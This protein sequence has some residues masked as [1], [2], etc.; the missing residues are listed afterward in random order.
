MPILLIRHGETAANVA[1]IMQR[2]DVPLSARG[3]RQAALLAERLLALGFAH[4]LCSDL[5]RARMTA[6][7]LVARGHTIE[8]TPL[9]QER[10]F[11]DLRGT[12]YAELTEDPFAP[13]FV[14]PG[15]ESVEVFHARVAQAFALIV[16]RR[17]A[18]AG[19]LVV[20]TH[21]LVCGALVRNHARAAALPEQFANAGI[22]VLDP[23]PPFVARLVN[24]TQHLVA[25]L[26]DAGGGPV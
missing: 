16:E 20:V 5:V 11:G 6:A 22:T 3:I 2:P 10:N 19:A 7:P 12:P 13:G 9:L 17:R 4:V 15:G 8:E 25:E 14:P 21:G 26:D 1:R 24:C 18:L 23:D